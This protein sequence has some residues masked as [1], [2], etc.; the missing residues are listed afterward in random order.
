MDMMLSFSQIS[1]LTV[2]ELRDWL[3]SDETDADTL[4]AIASGLNPRNG[5]AVSKLMRNQDLDRGSKKMRGGYPLP[6]YHWFKRPF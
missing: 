2:G 5:A 4:T 6:Q 1:H 3:L